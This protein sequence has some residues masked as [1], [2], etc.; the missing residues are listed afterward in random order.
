MKRRK[1]RRKSAGAKGITTKSAV[2]KE[3]NPKARIEAHA[4][5]RL[6]PLPADAERL[7]RPG[8]LK[9]AA[10]FV[11]YGERPEALTTKEVGERIQSLSWAPTGWCSRRLA[12]V[13]WE[14]ATSDNLIDEGPLVARDEHDQGPLDR[15]TWKFR[16]I[17]SE[18]KE[19][20]TSS[21]NGAGARA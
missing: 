3:R 1:V 9:S 20:V 2:A 7:P 11:L 5:F 18:S 15:K 4:A 14:M 8:G 6:I 16:P 17:E 19:R 21:T 10:I 13:L 12:T